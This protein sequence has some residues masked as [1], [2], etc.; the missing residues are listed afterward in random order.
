MT[1]RSHYR[2]ICFD[3][4]RNNMEFAV[5]ILRDLAERPPETADTILSKGSGAQRDG[6]PFTR[7]DIVPLTKNEAHDLR[8]AGSR[9][10]QPQ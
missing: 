8:D 9:P 10:I 6:S 4:L 2:C 5:P 3:S 7:R 1:R